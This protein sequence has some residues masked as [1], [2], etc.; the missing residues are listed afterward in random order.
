MKWAREPRMEAELGCWLS[1][2]VMVSWSSGSV[3]PHCP[4]SAARRVFAGSLSG[5]LSEPTRSPAASV[6]PSQHFLFVLRWPHLLLS[7]PRAGPGPSAFSQVPSAWHK[8]HRM[9]VSSVDS[10]YLILK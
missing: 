2:K 5:P 4:F 3:P 6:L 9:V 10:N 1:G 8:A 7:S